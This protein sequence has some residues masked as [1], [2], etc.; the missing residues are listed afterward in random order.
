MTLS[1][2][3]SV[4]SMGTLLLAGCVSVLPEPEAPDALYRIEGSRM[5]ANLSQN[6]V[7]R[8]PDAPR[9]SSGQ[10]MVSEDSAGIV[11]ATRSLRGR[12]FSVPRKENIS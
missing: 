9:L 12:N 3:I 5:V 10:S 7:V 6:V 2:S 8:E 4:L 1:K 11:P